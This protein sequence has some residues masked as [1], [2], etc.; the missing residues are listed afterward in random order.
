[1]TAPSVR[2][3]QI[4][5]ALAIY[6]LVGAIVSLYLAGVLYTLAN[7][8]MPEQLA[9]DLWLQAWDHY[10]DHAPQRGRLQFAAGTA[11]F[12]V[13]VLPVLI[14]LAHRQRPRPLH[15]EARFARTHEIARAG[16]FTR[17]P[18]IILGKRGKRYLVFAGQQFVLLAAPTR[19]GK[20]IGVVIPNLLNY[21]DSVVVLD[22]KRENFECTS[23]YR[24]E[25]GQKVY[26]FDPFAED[27]ATHCWNPLD[28]IR[29]D[30][31]L[32]VGD[33]L[34]IAQVLYPHDQT[35]ETFWNDQARNLFLGLTLYLLDTPTLPCTMGELLRQSSGKG[36]PLKDHL[37]AMLK[38]RAN[39]PKALC[40]TAQDAL[41]RF[42][43]TSDNTFSGILATFNAPLTIFANPIVDAATS[44]SDFELGV[45]RRQ[46]V[47]IYLCIAPSRLADAALLMN[48]FFSQLVNVNTRELP[49]DNPELR[50]PCLLILD[51]FTAIGRIGILAKGVAYLAGYNL[52]LLPIVQSVAQ[53]QTVYG[54]REARTFVTNHAVQIVF[55]PREQRDAVEYSEMLGTLTE[56]Q[57]SRSISRS[58][59]IDRVQPG[60]ISETESVQRRALLLP[61]ELKELGDTRAIVFSEHCKPILCEKIRY[62]AD[63]VLKHR[64][65]APLPIKPINF[66]LH[67][68]Q[69]EQ[70]IRV[71]KPGEPLELERIVKPTEL[72]VLD[73]PENPSDASVHA[74][75]D[76]GFAGFGLPSREA[77]QAMLL[78]GVLARE[79]ADITNPTAELESP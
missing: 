36:R 49:Q 22:I 79:Q 2:T 4:A 33:T 74:L 51:E 42:I 13:F 28:G 17:D 6:G 32:R 65:R 71:L 1:M 62:F 63:P 7:R 34:A 38:A 20:G 69:V 61:Q 16:L 40:D 29:R 23:G 64:K 21:P 57:R 24:A 77:T 39:G 60:S 78:R 68:A 70:R 19:S 59:G 14:V 47:S 73:D 45:V 52:R 56:T 10:G 55:A 46:R 41:N 50:V 66:E 67:Q 43:S 48:L 18:G 27:G 75:L 8:Q 30:R 35:R 3:L 15:G 11:L 9:W 26:C 12:A 25:C 72:P 58:R 37:V 54:D 31:H 44:R 53:L 76:S 5:G